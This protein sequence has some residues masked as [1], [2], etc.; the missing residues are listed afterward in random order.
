MSFHF[1]SAGVSR[2]EI[3]GKEFT[4]VRFGAGRDLFGSAPVF[5][6]HL[7]PSVKS[8][9]FHSRENFFNSDRPGDLVLAVFLDVITHE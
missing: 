1:R 3:D 9:G 2:G 5:G 6:N 7:V 4:G 8:A